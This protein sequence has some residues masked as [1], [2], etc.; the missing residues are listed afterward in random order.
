MST[1]HIIEPLAEAAQRALRAPSAFN[2]QPWRWRVGADVLELHADRTRQPAVTDPDGRLLTLGCG[3]AL[4]HAR[5]ALAASGFQTEVVRFPEASDPDLIARLRIAGRRDP[6]P[7]EVALDGAIPYRRT[8]RR[9]FSEMAVPPE[10]LARLRAAVEGEGSYLHLVR[11]DQMPMLAIAS[12][13]AATA[14]VA[15]PAYR[16]EVNHWTHRPPW[17]GDG[18]PRSAAVRQVPRRVP[19]R[20]HALDGEP[21]LEAGVGN[22]RGAAY[23]VLFGPDDTPASWLR[24]GEA[25]S[26]LLLTAVLEGLSAAP[27]SDTIE[28]DWPRHLMRDLIAGVGEPYLVIR[29]GVGPNPETLPAVPRRFPDDAIEITG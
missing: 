24:A 15:D 4:H 27:L 17:T 1:S 28:L 22:D 16:A 23:A 12:A 7:R 13:Q 3:A 14:E 11:G 21:G 29:V 8:D 6:D 5:V 20:D 2:S 10:A 18:V 9:A 25:L 19:V 26:A